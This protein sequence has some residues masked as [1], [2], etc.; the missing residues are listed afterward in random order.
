[1]RKRKYLEGMA[2]KAIEGTLEPDGRLTTTEPLTI[3]ESTRVIVTIEVDGDGEDNIDLALAS[4]KVWGRDWNRPEE[5][6]AW[7]YLQGETSS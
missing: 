1:M 3:T 2:L 6:E 7:A 4:E 5:D